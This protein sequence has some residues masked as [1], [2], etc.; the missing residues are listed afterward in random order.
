MDP[1]VVQSVCD[2]TSDSMKLKNSDIFGNLG[3]KLRHLS[4]S[5]QQ[6]QFS[7]LLQDFTDIF[8]DVPCQTTLVSHDVEVGD[9]PPSSNIPTVCKPGKAGGY[10]EGNRLY[11]IQW[12]N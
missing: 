5:P 6:T 1:V 4:C 7:P 11:A 8:L 9:S 10:E 3:T 12:L 2:V